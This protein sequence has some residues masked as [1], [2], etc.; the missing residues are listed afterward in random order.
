M[1][2]LLLTSVLI[3]SSVIA[4]LGQISVMSLQ[5]KIYQNNE[6]NP[7]WYPENTW[8]FGIPVISGITT[9]YN[10]RLRYNDVITRQD[11]GVNLVDLTKTL[12]ILK[13]NN[14]IGANV[15]VNDLFVGY[16]K[17]RDAISFFINDRVETDL[18]FPRDLI[19]FGVNGNLNFLDKNLNL[20][21]LALNASHYREFGIG[22]TSFGKN[23]K[24]NWG[25]RV[26]LLSGFYNVSIPNDFDATLTTNAD[27]FSLSID[28]DNAILRVTEVPEDG[29]FVF[30][31]NVGFSIDGGA[32]YRI[33]D[34]MRIAF[35]IR[36]LGFITWKDG[37]TH[38][39]LEDTEFT[40]GGVDIRDTD[41]LVEALEDSLADRFNY[42]AGSEE[43]YRTALPVKLNLTTSMRLT[44]TGE[45]VMMI[46][47]EFVRGFLQMRYGVGVTQGIGR[48]FRFNLSVNK[49]PQQGINFGTA[50]AVNLGPVQIYGG[51]DK[52]IGYDLTGLR[53][54]NYTFG[55]NVITGRLKSQKWKKTRL[56]RFSTN[57]S[58]NQPDKKKD[59]VYLN[60]KKEKN[61]R[62]GRQKKPRNSK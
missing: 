11:D 13:A 30:S 40:Y 34:R 60:I 35:A 49:L 47:P 38:R 31:P 62:K 50:L 36:D 21:K 53:S 5:N 25:Y 23:N 16:R 15:R 59:R 58:V 20:K 17:N 46:A 43:A 22:Y 3:I 26:K 2:K 10:N 39:E 29:S 14:Y 48:N 32:D 12:S 18:F 37:V 44:S 19:D 45:L 28:V 52:L 56:S 6:F 8:T 24:F 9:N 51:T 41:N 54:F 27:N 55:M 33:S 1:K 7:A 42:I 57:Q 61:R 4:S